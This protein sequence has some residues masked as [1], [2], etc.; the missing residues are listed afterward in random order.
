M[1][2]VEEILAAKPPS[3]RER[4]RKALEAKRAAKLEEQEEERGHL[5]A[6]AL[7]YL[8]NVLQVPHHEAEEVELVPGSFS[9]IRQQITF[10][11]DGLKFRVRYESKKIMDMRG[12]FGPETVYDLSPV[13][14]YNVK[15]DQWKRVEALSDLGESLA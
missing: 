4:A 7:H 1:T 6:D 5:R 15:G 9:A 13:L 14:E 12:E 11:V 3:L 8:V 2:T 10:V